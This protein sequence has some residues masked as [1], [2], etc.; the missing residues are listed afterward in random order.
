M[1]CHITGKFRI[2][3]LTP[4]GLVQGA[5]ALIMS[6]SASVQQLLLMALGNCRPE[7][8]DVLF[9][10]LGTW[11]DDWMKGSKLRG[12]LGRLEEVS[13][14]WSSFSRFWAGNFVAL[15]CCLIGTQVVD[16]MALSPFP[17][18]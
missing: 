1:Y 5:V 13:V 17:A 11:Y 2:G 15:G 4:R 8:Y 14:L 16:A 12:R 7:Y 18:R 10:E 9:D 3:Q 6:S